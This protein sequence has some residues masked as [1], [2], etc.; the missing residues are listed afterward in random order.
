MATLME[1][2]YICDVR[3]VATLHLRLQML[4]VIRLWLQEPCVRHKITQWPIVGNLCIIHKFYGKGTLRTGTVLNLFGMVEDG[5][6]CQICFVFLILSK[7]IFPWNRIVIVFSWNSF[8]VCTDSSFAFPKWVQ[9][10]HCHRTKYSLS[11]SIPV[12]KEPKCD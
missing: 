3:R 2:T 4:T 5:K 9:K 7:S 6:K 1:K 10:S 8:S 12:R 11:R